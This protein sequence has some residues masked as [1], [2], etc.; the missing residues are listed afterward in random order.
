MRGSM[1]A[2]HGNAF[3]APSLNQPIKCSR[4]RKPAN[5]IPSLLQGAGAS[6]FTVIQD[7]V[8]NTH[9]PTHRNYTLEARANPSNPHRNHTARTPSPRTGAGCVQACAPGRERAFRQMAF[10]RW[11]SSHV[12]VA[13]LAHGQHGTALSQHA[14]ISRPPVHVVQVGI[15]SQG[16]RIAPPE[17][18]VTGYMFGKGVSQWNG[19]E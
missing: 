13:W 8:A 5:E 17:A 4:V 14:Y 18:P 12:A 15:L 6:E 19:C 9:A 7:Y 11:P 16:L 1:V 2:L 3:V 10:G